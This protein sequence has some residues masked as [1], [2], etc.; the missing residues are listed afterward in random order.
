MSKMRCKC[1]YVIIDQTDSLPYK[2]YF[3]PDQDVDDALY[4]PIGNVAG[5][6]EARERGDEEGF[7]QKQGIK[8]MGASP[9]QTL[10]SSLDRLILDPRSVFQ[11]EM[12]E[13]ENCG[14]IWLEARSSGNEWVSYLP[15]SSKRGILRHGGAAPDA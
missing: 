1:G 13:C 9:E 5:F 7:L 10:E 3:L 6:I 12:Y 15:E 2:A 4:A 11:R 8:K 14:R